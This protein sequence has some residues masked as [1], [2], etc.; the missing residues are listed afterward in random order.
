M[1]LGE[2]IAGLRKKRNWT[3]DYF[4]E[5]VGVNGRHVSRW[6]NNHIRP[7]MGAIKRIAEVLGVTRDELLD[8]E[9]PMEEAFDRRDR[10]LLVRFR[11]VQD[12]CAEDRAMIFRMIDTL[13]TQKRLEKVLA[14]H[15][16]PAEDD[17]TDS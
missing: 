15:K 12:L 14:G 6:E 16:A 5:K 10:Q 13:T 1:T 11:A 2:K 3:Q 4:A 9:Q 8:D 17:G 7:S